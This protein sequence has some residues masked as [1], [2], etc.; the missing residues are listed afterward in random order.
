MSTT[1]KL[2]RIGSGALCWSGA[3]VFC[4]LANVAS[5]EPPAAAPP[6]R[7]KRVVPVEKL[8]V[9]QLIDALQEESEQG[10]GTHATA[11][12]S[13]FIGDDEPPRFGG[14]VL[15]SPRPVTSSVM[16]ELVR[17]G[18]AALPKLL[19]HIDDKRPT[20]FVFGGENR[21][22][23]GAAWH[24]DE[25]D[26][27]YADPKKQPEKVNTP[28]KDLKGQ[29]VNG[30]TVRVGDLCYVAVGQIV[31]RNLSV[32]RYQPTAILVINSPV[33]TPALAAAVRKDWADLTA[34]AHK[35]SL[36]QDAN[37][38]EPRFTASPLRRLKFYHPQAGEELAAKLL[39]RAP[40]GNSVVW[41]FA[42]SLRAE[43]D[44]TK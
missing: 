31:N 29:L 21:G 41:N 20:W 12:A 18:P 28:D 7:P 14:G 42:A 2:L 24:A 36:I 43:N 26:P 1:S 44:P 25:Y 40:V 10:I 37:S 22:I 35:Q 19:E 9:E 15:G 6:P 4:A 39:A 32:F 8:T 5:A 34:E 13:G 38:S 27:R 23:I 33:E 3:L 17:R 16:R 11:L 30:Y